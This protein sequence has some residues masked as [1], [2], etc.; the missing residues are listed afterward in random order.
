MTAVL[1]ALALASARAADLS[2]EARGLE[3]LIVIQARLAEAELE[4]GRA[5]RAAAVLDDE[6]RRAQSLLEERRRG[7][8]RTRAVLRRRLRA[9][10][11]ARERGLAESLL[12]AA[13]LS[14][15][16]RRRRSI[17]RAAVDDAARLRAYARELAQV[18]EL[19]AEVA[20]KG[21]RARALRDAAVRRRNDLAELR[22]EREATLSAL[23]R[24]GAEESLSRRR[25]A[26]RARLARLVRA[27]RAE[28]GRAGSIRALRGRLPHPI[29]GRIAVPFGSVRE[30]PF[31]TIAVHSGW[32]YA[33]EPGTRVGAVYA[34]RVVYARRF[35]GYGNLLIVDHGGKVHSLS[36]R[37]AEI[38]V[39]EGEEVAAG[40][41]VGTTGGERRLRGPGLYF[42][43]RVG[44][45]PVDPADWLAPHERPA[46]LRASV[47]P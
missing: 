20:R 26:S 9:L 45:R 43:L 7:L 10:G 12:S 16:R 47:G 17:A 13:R 32:Q 38:R 3:D 46:R 41:T 44:G 29:E 42:E 4:A 35:P 25:A 30:P 5:R 37:L 14:D 11:R 2:A 33:V 18:E 21:T 23:R 31:G 34:G 24:R 19:A 39:R 6:L 27:L 40:Q 36:A 15:W 28:L 8:G 1:L 22:R